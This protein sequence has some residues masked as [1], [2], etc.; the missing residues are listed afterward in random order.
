MKLRQIS[1]L[2]TGII[3]ASSVRAASITV[4][5]LQEFHAALNVAE[6]NGENDTIIL[7][8]GTYN[9]LDLGSDLL[10]YVADGVSVENCALSIKCTNGTAVM[11]RPETV[12][13]HP[14]HGI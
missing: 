10:S 8:P 3:I 13:S 6:T 14:V 12:V 11:T 2:L 4:S 5:T 9:V 7:N 1:I